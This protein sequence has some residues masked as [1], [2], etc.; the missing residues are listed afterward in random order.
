MQRSAA[1]H[2]LNRHGPNITAG[3]AE[4]GVTR[5][6]IFAAHQILERAHR[7]EPAGTARDGMERILAHSTFDD[8]MP[9]RLLVDRSTRSLNIVSLYHPTKQGAARSSKRRSRRK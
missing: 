6:D 1:V 4:R 5:K 2:I 7:F 3:T 8:G 9:A